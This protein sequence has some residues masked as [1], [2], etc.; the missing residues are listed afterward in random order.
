MVVIGSRKKDYTNILD[1]IT[2]SGLL[3]SPQDLMSTKSF[4]MIILEPIGFIFIV[5][6]NIKS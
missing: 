5:L 6:N 3:L 1:L 2:L 4:Q